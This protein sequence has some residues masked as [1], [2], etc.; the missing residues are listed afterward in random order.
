MADIFVG[1]VSV[2][3]VPDARGWDDRM[4]AQILPGSDSV[5]KEIGGIIGKAIAD[6]LN[7]GRAVYDS[8]SR[9]AAMISAAGARAAQ[10]FADAFKLRLDAALKTMRP[11]VTVRAKL[12]T[13]EIAGKTGAA[14]I[15][16]NVAGGAGAGG[17]GGGS[18]LEGIVPGIA[19]LSPE[20][21]LALV[22]LVAA[23]AP[24]IAEAL[25]LAIVTGFGAGIAAIAIIG[26]AKLK[27]VQDAFKALT[28]QM[29]KDLQSVGTAF[30][31]VLLS[32]IGTTV[33]VM[34]KLTPVFVSAANIIAGPFQLFSDTLIRSFSSPIVVQSIY[35]I[36][37][38][39]G[40]I[41]RAV[42][43]TLPTDVGQIARGIQNIAQAVAAHPEA[44]AQFVTFLFRIAEG[45]LDIISSLMR[46]A[47]WIQA[48]WQIIRWIVFPVITAVQEIV[49]NWN[50]L[51]NSTINIFNSIIHAIESA[52]DTVWNNTI[53]RTQNGVN[54]L[55][56]IFVSLRNRVTSFFSGA[57]SWLTNAGSEVI[58]GFLN[59]IQSAMGGISG[60]IKS[61]VVDPVI[62]AVKHFFG[63]S[64]PATVMMPVGANVIQGML[65]GMLS[66]GADLGTFVGKIFGGWPQALGSLAEKSLVDI[67]KLPQK[68]LSALGKVG[69]AIGGFLSKAL[70]FSGS[71]GVGQWAGVVAQALAMNGLPLSLSAQVLRQISSE[72]G[73]N[74]NAINNSDIN[75]QM[76]DPSRGLLQTIGATFS[77]YH[78]GGTSNNIYDP[79]ANVAAAINYAKNVYGPG[80]MS[81]GN[82]LGSGHGYDAGGWLPPGYTMAYNGTG[83]HELVLTAD[84]LAAAQRGSDGSAQYVAHFDSL[85]GAAIEAHVRTAYTA[86][87]MQQGQANRNGRRS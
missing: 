18:A 56:N 52:W 54:D 9:G 33:G 58:H 83:R 13:T 53:S 68:A 87:A 85:T 25:S 42:A 48:N 29:T 12:D 70:G 23:A 67:A 15:A 63:I 84:Q 1:S 26:A 31:P 39:F 62:N 30:E 27:P 6:N 14:D 36:A 66:S 20:V 47:A 22:G 46:V 78:V 76:G 35:S 79:L 40:D 38:S 80:L 64:S 75:A 5:G 73:G 45:A 16:G 74:P 24:F 3:V 28:S 50:N 49:A 65:K 32:I 37:L 4:R 61:V 19:G 55:V 69:G 2:G 86:M 34:A 11:E 77:A 10:T 60:W 59:G 72:S 43:G 44:I 8:T 21:T 71:S 17:A 7:V 81:G 57:E 41:L 82:G 51:R